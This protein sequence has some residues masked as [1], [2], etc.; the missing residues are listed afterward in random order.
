[1]REPTLCKWNKD[2]FYNGV[3]QVFSCSC[4]LITAERTEI[5]T[6]FRFGYHTDGNGNNYRW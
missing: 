1:M 5:S 3:A 4:D 2:V 6:L